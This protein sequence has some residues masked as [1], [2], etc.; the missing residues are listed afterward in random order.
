M[1]RLIGKSLSTQENSEIHKA[2]QHANLSSKA[3]KLNSSSSELCKL[4]PT[5]THKSSQPLMSAASSF[6]SR[7]DAYTRS[8]WN[9]DLQ[10]SALHLH[11]ITNFWGAIALNPAA[12]IHLLQAPTS[13]H[14]FIETLETLEKLLL[15]STVLKIL[16]F[17][18]VNM[19]FYVN[20]KLEVSEGPTIVIPKRFQKKGET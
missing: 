4:L 5:A 12:R 13:T 15:F 3:T 6:R 2:G 16:I 7:E 17:L 18:F 8:T 1:K 14:C 19:M 20:V 9:P 11:P 10:T